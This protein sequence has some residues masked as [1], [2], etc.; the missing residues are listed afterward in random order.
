M[1]FS[2]ME[3]NARRVVEVHALRARRVDASVDVRLV[4]SGEGG[5]AEVGEIVAA[6]PDDQGAHD[7]IEG[8]GSSFIEGA[9]DSPE[10]RLGRSSWSWPH[11]EPVPGRDRRLVRRR[12][13]SDAS[14]R[15]FTTLL[16]SDVGPASDLFT[17]K[18]VVHPG[19]QLCS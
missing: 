19:P 3:I 10:R 15:G 18:V 6:L 1:H 16:T 13:G 8:C 12:R 9:A 4:E 11:P 14:R 17:S 5:V 2:S 7:L